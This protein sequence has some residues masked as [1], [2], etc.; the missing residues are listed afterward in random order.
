MK[1]NS[2][3]KGFTIV[4][5]V[6]VVAVIAILSAVLIPTF[7][8]VVRNA[9]VSND[10]SLIRNLNTALA[11][12]A[13]EETTM[14]D[15]LDAAEEH[16]FIV[17]KIN[18]TASDAE[19]LWDSVKNEF[20]Y[21]DNGSLAAGAHL[22]AISSTVSNKYSTYLYNA[23]STAVS[24]VYS[25]DVGNED[26]EKITYTGANDVE[27]YTN[28]S[29]TALEINAPEATVKHYGE[30]GNVNV[31]AV[32][33]TNCYHE[34]GV[35][36][37]TLT[38]KQGKLVV[39]EK[40]EVSTVVVDNEAD[41]SKISVEVKATKKPAIVAPADKAE[42]LA[43]KVSGTTVV[44]KTEVASAD[45]LRAALLAKAA[46]ISLTADI[47]ENVK[48]DVTHS[49]IIDGNGKTMENAGAKRNKNSS[50][51]VNMVVSGAEGKIDVEIRNL[52]IKNTY[53]GGSNAGRPLETRGNVNSLTLVNVTLDTSATTGQNKQPLT[54]GSRQ[55]DMTKVVLKN[56]KLLAGEGSGYAFI[57]FNPVDLTVDEC[58]MVGYSTLYFKGEFDSAGSEGS[59][60]NITD[61]VLK[62]TSKDESSNFAAI[63]L[64]DSNIQIYIDSTEI[65]AEETAAGSQYLFCFSWQDYNPSNAT[66]NNTPVQN[67]KITVSGDT[68]ITYGKLV[69]DN[70]IEKGVATTNQL[71]LQ[72]GTYTLIKQAEEVAAYVPAGYVAKASG[73]KVIVTKA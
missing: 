68:T 10:K 40:A 53:T 35:V 61:S 33:E 47:T 66:D 49:C 3:K 25:L 26:I 71:V 37:G 1:K 32:D 48:F 21:N 11:A 46:Y 45:Q 6:I 9:N 15:A 23:K 65:V 42:A 20:V 51:I 69:Q 14:R 59:I 60:V 50:T 5:L 29:K 62:S 63:T 43:S 58:E 70:A 36:A 34:N 8:A 16:G 27:I 54:I 30:V 4:E 41:V 18:A 44:E 38:L 57:T 56:S 72:G 67:N 24:A 12:N 13:E 52:T 55:A 31:I 64:E 17:E 73:T 22:W 2:L 7:S 28:S 39:A 19:I